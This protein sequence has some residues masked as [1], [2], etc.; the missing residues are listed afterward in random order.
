LH[1]SFAEPQRTT[2]STATTASSMSVCIF[3]EST[4]SSKLRDAAA[5][6][7]EADL[8]FWL[9]WE[10]RG[11]SESDDLEE[12]MAREHSHLGRRTQGFLRGD[13]PGRADGQEKSTQPE[14]APT[15]IALVSPRTLSIVLSTLLVAACRQAAPLA[16]KAVSL[17]NAGVEALARGDLETAGARFDLALEYNGRFLEALVNQGLVEMER[18]NFARARQLLTRARRLNPDVAQPHHALGVLEE[19]ESRPDRASAHYLEALRVDPGFAPS[20]ANLARLY[21]NARRYERAALEFRRLVEV[22]P[23][24][25]LAYS[26]LVD[27]LLGLGRTDEADEW[28]T[29]AVARFPKSTELALLQARH[30]LRQGFF[31][32]VLADLRPLAA[33]RDDTAIAALGWMATAEL[34][35][36]RPRLAVGAAQK[37]LSLSPEDPVATYVLAT[38]LAQLGDKN[39]AEWRARAQELLPEHPAVAGGQTQR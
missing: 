39:A 19:R 31:D 26:G 33:R 7:S 1:A 2:L 13:R 4:R 38:A 21:F 37:A 23:D 9:D 36:G 27:S 16:P 28:L 24:D 34:A 25:P 5:D 3:G 18:G 14:N 17:N 8:E 11:R 35:A 32:K 20:R 29:K 22:A 30:D 10:R 12:G 6:D 15:D